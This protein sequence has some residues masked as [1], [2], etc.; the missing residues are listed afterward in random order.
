MDSPLPSEAK[1]GERLVPV[2]LDIAWKAKTYYAMGTSGVSVSCLASLLDVDKNKVQRL[3]NLR[4]G[5]D[6]LFP[7]QA[8][9]AIFEEANY[10]T[11]RRPL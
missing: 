8:L 6:S 4:Y 10:I 11:H 7:K 3:L 1:E 2:P 5:T 9:D